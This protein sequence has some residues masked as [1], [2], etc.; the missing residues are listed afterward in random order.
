M[1]VGVV[2]G[3]VTATQLAHLRNWLS[4][5]SSALWLQLLV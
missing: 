4:G 3:S 1:L 2:S 5:R